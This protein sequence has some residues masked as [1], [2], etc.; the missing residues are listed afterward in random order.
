MKQNFKCE[1]SPSA[2]S[3]NKSQLEDQA[4]FKYSKIRSFIKKTGIPSQYLKIFSKTFFCSTFSLFFYQQ[5]I[6]K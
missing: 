3:Q 5:G 2:A 6:Q 1:Q 4:K